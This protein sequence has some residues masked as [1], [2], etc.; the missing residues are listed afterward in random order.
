MTRTP[1]VLIHGA[2]LHAMCGRRGTPAPEGG[3]RE[4]AAGALLLISGQEDRMVPDS[5]TRSVYKLYDDSTATSDLEHFPDRAHSL[6]VDSGWRS[7]ADHVL[8][9]LAL[10]DIRGL[11][12]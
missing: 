7:A 5:V 12:A 11:D 10:Q 9:R 3:H 4:R 6:T 8:L 1:V 2:W